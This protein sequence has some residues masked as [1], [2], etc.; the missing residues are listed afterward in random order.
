MMTMSVERFVAWVALAALGSVGIG[1]LTGFGSARLGNLL[2]A[3][4]L[5]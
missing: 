5:H 1:I 2:V 4:L 3:S